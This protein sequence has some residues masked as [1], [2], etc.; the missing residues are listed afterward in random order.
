MSWV[1]TIIALVVESVVVEGSGASNGVSS[2]EELASVSR[3]AGVASPEDEFLCVEGPDVVGVLSSS[4]DPRSRTCNSTAGCFPIFFC[5]L[6]PLLTLA[7]LVD[8]Q[9][10]SKF[11]RQQVS[12]Y[13]ETQMRDTR[14]NRKKEKRTAKTIQLFVRIFS[15]PDEDDRI[16]QV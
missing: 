13:F 6:S 12:C 8:V 9:R 10:K 3:V 1:I 2:S 14:H 5:V 11:Q 4:L 7:S 15:F 16:L